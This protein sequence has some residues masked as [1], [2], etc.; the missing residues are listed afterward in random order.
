MDKYFVRTEMLIGEAGLNKLKN[1][2]VA[3]FGI[4]GVGAFAA[5]AL[6][7]SA[8]GNLVL[9]DFD[10]IAESNI[11]R[12]I[13][14][15]LETVGRNKVDV[16]KERIL[17]INP[18][19]TV[20][21]RV[22]MVTRENMGEFITEDLDYVIDAIDMVSSKIA[23]IEACKAKGIRIISAMGAGNK[24]SPTM[25]EVADLYKTSVCPLAKVMRREL[26]ARGVKDLKVVYSK[27]APIRPLDLEAPAA[28]RRQTP[29]SV[30]FVPSAS[31]LIIA[32]EVV[33]DLIG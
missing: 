12:Q 5:E 20:E 6:A 7:R 28:G 18:N 23:L 33:K 24:L 11:N 25:L 19:C 29:G 31:G 13:H 17:S 26:R 1:S 9:V 2:K 21:A 15:T 8:V 3:I 4:G 27:E 22:E 10:S 30:S 16:M 14:S 32:S